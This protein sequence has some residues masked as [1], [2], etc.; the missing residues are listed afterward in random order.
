MAKAAPGVT[1]D[2]I[3]DLAQRLVQTRGFNAFSYADLS[4]ELGIRKASIHHHFPTKA[5]LGRRLMSRYR[6]TFLGVLAAID[7]ESPRAA[8][9][10]KRYVGLYQDVLRNEDR[11][12]LCGMLAADF[13]TLPET[14]RDA[15]QDFFNANE[16]WLTGLLEKGRKDRELHFEGPPATQARLLVSGLEG[17]MLVARTYGDL[18]RFED[19]AS[20]LLSRLLPPSSPKRRS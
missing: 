18:S 7:R 3:L 13:K 19:V 14:L 12:C 11:M 1:A 8:D 6:D 4:G 5:E 9:K 20:G 2:R 15:V 10:L 17:A 16:R